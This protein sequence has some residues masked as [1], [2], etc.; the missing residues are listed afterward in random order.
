MKE[1]KDRVQSL[2]LEEDERDGGWD[3]G[4]AG[5]PAYREPL[6]SRVPVASGSEAAQFD[7]CHQ[8]SPGKWTW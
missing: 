2:L 7:L 6:R 5:Q 8:G 3:L 1:G 4:I